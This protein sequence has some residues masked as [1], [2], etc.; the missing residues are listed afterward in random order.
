MA[1]QA[2]AP[3]T[4]KNPEGAFNPQR[5]LTQ[6]AAGTVPDVI[7]LDRQQVATLAAKG[8]LQPLDKC[9]DQQSIDLSQYRKAALDEASY[10]DK[11]YAIPEFTQPAD[12]D[13]QHE[14]GAGGRREALGHPD[15]DWDKLKVVAKKLTKMDGGKLAR[16]GF[17]PKIPEFFL[18][19]AKANGADL[20]SADGQTAKLD[21]PKAVEALTFTKSLID[22]QGGW[23]QFKAFRDTW[24]FFG[25]KNP[26]AADQIG[27]WPME[28]WYWNVLSDTSPDA[29]VAAV[30]FTDR[31]GN[32]L[33]FFTGAG[34]AIP[35]GAK[36]PSLA[37]T[38]MKSMTSVKAWMNAAEKRAASTKAS[39]QAFTG[40]Y[41]A[42]ATA[43]QRI[44]DEVYK[45]SSPAYDAAVKLLVDVQKNAVWWPAS[46]AGAQIQQAVTDAIN[47]V[48]AGSQTPQ[49]SLAR[50][51]QEA[52][53]AI[54]AAR[55][56]LT[57]RVSAAA[58]CT[59]GRPRPGAQ[60]DG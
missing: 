7:Y 11:L 13:R 45:P 36:N 43:D 56:R 3:A 35:K 60:L 55:P 31:H 9:V 39:G 50:A 26:V 10:Q 5:F 8:A 22:E 51:Q 16:I 40:L 38:W 33:T 32:D 30:P 37:C 19:W 52:Q 1:K 44:L 14:G 27:A 48:L 54:D 18:M 24:D 4:V 49:Q 42:N 25:A 58:A 20:L 41:T 59:I 6:L 15:D 47:R 53:K 28:S 2:I 57:R 34:W 46:P 23:Q 12:P 21:D 17:D 29:G